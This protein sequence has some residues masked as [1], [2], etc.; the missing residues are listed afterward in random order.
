[1]R[2]PAETGGEV[3]RRPQGEHPGGLYRRKEAAVIVGS[4]RLFLSPLDC[5]GG[6]RR[7]SKPCRQ[8]APTGTEGGLN[9]RISALRR[10]W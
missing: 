2:G 10:T 8:D 3:P 7:L 1:M 4:R 5:R 6:I 9:G